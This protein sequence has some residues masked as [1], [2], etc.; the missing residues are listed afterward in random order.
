MWPGEWQRAVAAGSEY[1]N[2]DAAAWSARMG[3]RRLISDIEK[4]DAALRAMRKRI[5]LLVD[6]LV[7]HRGEGML[8]RWRFG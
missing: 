7:R 2:M 6:G 8:G 1:A 3:S 4:A 5:R